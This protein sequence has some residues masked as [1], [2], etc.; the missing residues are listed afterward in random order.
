MLIVPTSIRAPGCITVNMLSPYLGADLTTVTNV[1]FNVVRRDG[2]T[3]SWTGVIIS[4]TPGELIVQYPFNGTEFTSTGLY[5]LSPLLTL[6]G[7][8]IP[9]QTVSLFVTNNNQLAPNVETTAFLATTV[10]IQTPG[11]AKSTWNVITTASSPVS[12]SPLSPWYA[13]DLRTGPITINLW[14]AQDGDIFIIDD[15]FYEASTNNLILNGA[16]GQLLPNGDGTFVASKTYTSSGVV[17]RLKY[18]ATESQWL[19]W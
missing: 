13:A 17:L 14:T 4:S 7:G 2:T 8:T 15:V 12:P 16:A 9:G 19:S 11:Q 18:S 10:Q 6:P 3:T 5:L 1:V